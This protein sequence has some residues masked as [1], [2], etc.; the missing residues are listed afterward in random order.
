METCNADNELE[1]LMQSM[2]YHVDL[3]NKETINLQDFQQLLSDFN[4]KFNYV[5]LEFNM[6]SEG[7]SNKK[8][9]ASM[10]TIR[11]TFIGE[12]QNTVESIYVDPGKIKEI[13]KFRIEG[14]IET[15]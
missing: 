13:Q 8:L 3:A 12:V 1:S 15:E 10:K 4:D 7:K 9:H 11:S 5:E 6:S 14:K 2:M